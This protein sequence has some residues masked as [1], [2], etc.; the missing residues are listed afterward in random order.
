MNFKE[1]MQRFAG[2]KNELKVVFV[3]SSDPQGVPNSAPKM[4]IDVVLPNK[5][6]FL[7]YCFTRTFSNLAQ[8]PKVSLSIMNDHE[9]TG[10]RLS[11][12]A[13][14]L[15]S[16]REFERVQRIW[17]KRL[18]SYE[19]KRIV[20]RVRG[21]HSM[22]EAENALPENFAIVKLNAL[23]GSVVKPDRVLRSTHRPK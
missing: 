7:E 15:K 4:L 1:V 14:F 18:I 10:Y 21:E 16:G 23:E 19:A 22:R 17:K 9:F 3:A 8:N 20:E 11:G 5:I 2:Q 13:E 12:P 6:Y